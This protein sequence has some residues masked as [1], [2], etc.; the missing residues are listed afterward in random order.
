MLFCFYG[1]KD[2]LV[3]VHTVLLTENRPELLTAIGLLPCI[4]HLS[5][6]FAGRGQYTRFEQTHLPEMQHHFR[7]AACQEYSDCRMINRPIWQNAHK[8]W[9]LSI[10]LDPILHGWPSQSR[11]VSNGRNM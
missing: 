6:R 8:A 1:R 11:C 5:Q 7:D 4:Q 2:H 10:H 9:S 3:S